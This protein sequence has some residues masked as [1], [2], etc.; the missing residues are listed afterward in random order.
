MKRRSSMVTLIRTHWSKISTGLLLATLLGAGGMKVYEPVVGD[1]CQP[2]AS[3][4]HPGSP[5]CN[6]HQKVAL[7]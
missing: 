4:C 2:G 3:C 7:R 5:C 1:C 6:H